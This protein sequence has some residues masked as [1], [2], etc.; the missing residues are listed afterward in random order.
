MDAE[1]VA[2]LEYAMVMA[3]HTGTNTR[4]V[5]TSAS[6]SAFFSV[7]VSCV[8]VCLSFTGT[9]VSSSLRR[10]FERLRVRFSVASDGGVRPNHGVQRLET[11]EN[12]LRE[13]RRDRE[14]I[15]KGRRR[16]ERC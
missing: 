11:T 13:E 10:T 12:H 5:S 4:V 7:A 8:C 2:V 9:L 1:F 16:R 15:E 14:G 3:S 6:T